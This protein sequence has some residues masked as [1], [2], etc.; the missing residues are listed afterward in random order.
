MQRRSRPELAKTVLE[1]ARRIVT[2]RGL[3]GFN[4][5]D[6]AAA[7][8]C[9]VGTLY[10][11]YPNLES[12]LL[13]VNGE[14][15]DALLHGLRTATCGTTPEERLLSQARAYVAFARDN[16][17]LY[18]ALLDRR[19]T[20]LG[21]PP[22]DWFLEKVAAIRRVME[23]SLA[24]LLPAEEAEA[25]ECAAT[26]VWASLNGLCEAIV[27]GNIQSV[28]RV[29][30]DRLLVALVETLVTGLRHRGGA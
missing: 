7:S 4:A 13:Q 12:V 22:P 29:D 3:P 2:E 15:L 11:L 26:N 5:R 30:A 18:D 21:G 8:G 27:T 9:S 1:E 16:R 19:S 28:T 23:E 25:L 6:L 14:T 20:A 10:N 17:R 24:P